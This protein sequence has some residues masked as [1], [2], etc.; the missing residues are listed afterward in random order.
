MNDVQQYGLEMMKRDSKKLDLRTRI[1][2]AAR[3]EIAEKGL[4]LLKAREVAT[5]ASSAL[6]GLYTV[7]AD[8]DAIV[9]AVNQDSF[10]ALDRIMTDAVSNETNPARK[11]SKLIS[12]YLGFARAEPFLWRAMFEHR[13]A[14]GSAYPPSHYDS[15]VRLMAHI[16]APLGELRMGDSE[17]QRFTRARTLYSAFHGIIWMSL[18]ERFTGLSSDELE[19]ELSTVLEQLLRGAGV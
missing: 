15:L 18:D 17:Q 5:R 2:A 9:L 11:L 12:A 8:L 14:M 3:T 4:S 7:F 19:G 1:V 6:G 10:D 13:L 16:A